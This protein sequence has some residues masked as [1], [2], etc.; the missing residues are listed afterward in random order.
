MVGAEVVKHNPANTR[1]QATSAAFW[2][3]PDR[4]G[5]NMTDV[6]ARWH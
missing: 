6:G 2:Q 4:D 3:L 5:L 1:Q